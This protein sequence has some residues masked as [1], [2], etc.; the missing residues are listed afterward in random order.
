MGDDL[1]SVGTSSAVYYEY[2]A[3]GQ[4]VRADSD[5]EIDGTVDGFEIYENEF[6]R[7]S[8]REVWLAQSAQFAPPSQSDSAGATILISRE[9]YAYDGGGQ[10]AEVAADVYPVPLD[11]IIDQRTLLT[12]SNGQVER[13]EVRRVSGELVA[14]ADYSYSYVDGRMSTRSTRSSNVRDGFETVSLETY[15]YDAQGRMTSL[16][17]AVS[18]QGLPT[19]ECLIS[20]DYNADGTRAAQHGCS[21]ERVLL[22]GN[23][24]TD[25]ERQ[26][27]ALAQLGLTLDEATAGTKRPAAIQLD[28]GGVFRP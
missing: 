16:A 20:F 22:Y 8:L 10:L 24:C 28:P 15:S 25:P 3:S 21:S 18:V 5:H 23:Q 12:Y 19:T 6:E 14:A 27:K 11:G 9:T 13:R 4:Q 17:L 1:Q 26:R 2:D 7:R